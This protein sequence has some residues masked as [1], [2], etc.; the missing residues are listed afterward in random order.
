MARLILHL[1]AKLL[2]PLDVDVGQSFLADQLAEG[3]GLRSGWV[4]LLRAINCF[5]LYVYM[6]SHWTCP[7]LG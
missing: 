7:L 6:I 4:Y 1:G 5:Y 2:D 3:F